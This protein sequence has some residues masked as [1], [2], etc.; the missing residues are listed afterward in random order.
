MEAAISCK[1]H[2]NRLAEHWRGY[3]PAADAA[4]PAADIEERFATATT[5]SSRLR[6]TPS[7]SGDARASAERWI[8]RCAEAARM[9]PAT[10]LE[11]PRIRARA[12]LADPVAGPACA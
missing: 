4:E 5:A 9:D 3:W 2:C 1:F 7:P 10:T 6:A 8:D 11:W 12:E